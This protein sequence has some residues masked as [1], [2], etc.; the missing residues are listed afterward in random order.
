M[1]IQYRSI[2]LI[3]IQKRYLD[4]RHLKPD[5]MRVQIIFPGGGWSELNKPKKNLIEKGQFWSKISQYNATVCDVYTY[6]CFQMI[7]KS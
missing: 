2:A 7:P 6:A 4:F 3:I 1:H 5:Q